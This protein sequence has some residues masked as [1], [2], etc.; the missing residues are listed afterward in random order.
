M[1]L[2]KHFVVQAIQ[3]F[4]IHDLHVVIFD[5]EKQIG[6]KSTKPQDDVFVEEFV[7]ESKLLLLPVLLLDSQSEALELWQEFEEGEK[8]D[9]RE[10]HSL[11]PHLQILHAVRYKWRERIEGHSSLS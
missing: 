6:R 10:V 8:A 3:K 7:A 2:E 5:S 9:L 11:R 1:L 4:S